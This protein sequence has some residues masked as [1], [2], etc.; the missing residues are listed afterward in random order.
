MGAGLK[1]LLRM[2]SL[3]RRRCA[4]GIETG[5]SLLADLRPLFRDVVDQT[6]DVSIAI[7]RLELAEYLGL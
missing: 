3:E 4:F 6:L 2:R 5:L 7:I 1:G